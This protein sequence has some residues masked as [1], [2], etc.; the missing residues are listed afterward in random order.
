M[1]VKCDVITGIESENTEGV[2]EKRMWYFI[3]S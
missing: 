2:K 1:Y 3:S